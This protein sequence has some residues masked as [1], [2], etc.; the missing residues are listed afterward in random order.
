MKRAASAGRSGAGDIARHPSTAKF[1]ATKFVRHF[2]ADDR[3]RAGGA[4]AGQFHAHRRD[5]RALAL[6][7]VDSEE[8]WKAPLTKVRNPYEFLVATGRLQA[9]VPTIPVY[10][11][12]PQRAGQP[13]WSPSGPNGFPIP[14]RRGRAEA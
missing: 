2:V 14:M 13:L 10:I 11:S 12:R 6:T 4:I 1:I 5:L 3:R 9:R 8:A 7:L